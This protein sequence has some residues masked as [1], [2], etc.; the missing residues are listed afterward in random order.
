MR[1]FRL[2]FFFFILSSVLF[3]CDERDFDIPA[4]ENPQYDGE[5]TMT[6]LEFIEKYRHV[7]DTLRI[8]DEDIIS[9]YITAND[10]SGN[11]Y[12]QIVIQD[13]TAAMVISIDQTNLYNDFVVGQLVFVECKD[14]YVGR[15]YQMLQL[16]EYY[17]SGNYSQIGRMDW[18]VAKSKIHKSGRPDPTVIEPEIITAADYSKLTD[19]YNVGKLYKLQ[20]VMF[21]DAGE[22]VFATDAEVS[23]NAVDKVVYF[24][25][26]PSNTVTTRNSTYADFAKLTVPEGV[27]SLVGV[28][29]TYLGNPQFMMRSAEDIL[30][31]D[32]AE[33]AGTK[34]SPWSVNYALTHQ[35]GTA[36]GWIQGYIVGT[37]APGINESNPV[38]GNSSFIF[39][40]TFMN[41]TVVLAETPNVQDWTKCVIVNLPEGSALRSQV[42]LADHPSLLGQQLSVTGT[43]QNY[44]GGAGVVVRTGNT[45]EFVSGDGLAANGD[46]TKENPYTVIGAKSNQGAAENNNYKWVTGYVV[47]VYETGSSPFTP[48][49]TA[50]FS[51]VSNLLLAD[52]PDVTELAN[53]LTVQIPTGTIRDDLSP[54]NNPSILKQK[55]AVQGS[56]ETYFSIPGIKNLQ[57]YEIDGSSG[58]GTDPGTDP[59]TGTGQSSSEPFSVAQAITN[60]GTSSQTWT[61]G[62]I[63][64]C[65]KNG[66]STVSSADDVIIGVTSGWDSY[67]NVMIADS[68]NETNYT[69]CVIV[70]LPS[71]TPLRSQVNLF[72]NPGTYQKTLTVR[73]VLRTYFGQSGLRDSAGETAD[74][75]LE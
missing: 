6:I 13:H 69:N 42:N 68:P 56:L 38:T 48:S 11:I 41:N 65:V 18:L 46:G 75:I 19:E 35:E 60:Q 71:G 36:V 49:F 74:F 61:K 12:K 73:G 20:D 50:P 34:A 15:T 22:K 4:F 26:N 45:D 30:D 52:S 23:G 17:Q 59:G 2:G 40:G 64:G 29:S 62:Y 7:E 25:E 14:L 9:G 21:K 54:V 57:G 33:G 47:G 55:I 70:N 3:S 16:G 1:L 31:F 37:V 53:C 43:L 51:T 72:D 5:A 8:T 24:V 58:G 32:E 63:V 10:I 27:G 28:L 39:S 66:M 44:L 67:T